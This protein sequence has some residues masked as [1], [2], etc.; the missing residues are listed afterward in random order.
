MADEPDLT[1]TATRGPGRPRRQPAPIGTEPRE[2]ILTAAAGLFT[3]QGYSAT[4]T[5]EIAAAAG[6]RPAS[7]FYWFPRKEDILAEL[8]DRTVTPALAVSD[9]LASRDV[10]ADVALYLL[11]RSDVRNLCSGVHNVAALQLL[12]EA[13][14]ETFASFWSQRAELRNRYRRLVTRLGRED[15]LAVRPV[16]LATD[17]AFGTV[18][19]VITWFERGGPTTPDAAA[20]A[21]ALAVVRGTVLRPTPPD[22]LRVA[23]ARLD[24]AG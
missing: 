2:E 20:D 4:G 17:V 6:L 23:G 5:R 13:R 10:A 9:A 24:A 8:L 3:E 15:R 22:R 18:E 12:P 14:G 19:S 21:V 1:T 16:A 11:A 7:L